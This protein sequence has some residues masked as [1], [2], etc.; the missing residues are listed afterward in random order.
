M[1]TDYPA[2]E[3][4]RGRWQR[5]ARAP[6][7]AAAY[8]PPA[9][10]INWLTRKAFISCA[11]RCDSQQTVRLLHDMRTHQLALALC[12]SLLLS[13]VVEEILF[14]WLLPAGLRHLRV[15]ERYSEAVAALL[16][17]AIHPIPWAWPMLVGFALAQSH[18]LRR[19]GLAFVILVHAFFN[20]W[21]LLLL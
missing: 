10:A 21:Q 3:A 7:V 2:D 20:A 4:P 5:L 15:A 13:P 11:I 17:A 9:F 6:L 12:T 1:T 18:C 8:I 19:N 16:F 14:R